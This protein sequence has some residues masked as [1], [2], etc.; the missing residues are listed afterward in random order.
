MRLGAVVEGSRSALEYR[1]RKGTKDT[2]LNKD[3]LPL[4]AGEAALLP[5]LNG[6]ERAF[7]A[8]MFCLDHERLRH[9]GREILEARDDV[10]QILFSAGTGIAELRERLRKLH[11]DADALWGG[12]RAYRPGTRY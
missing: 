3:G 7:Y 6:V 1:R 10:G 2:L 11:A 12:R 4:P 8:R 5:F 9:G